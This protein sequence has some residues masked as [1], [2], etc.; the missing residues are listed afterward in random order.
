VFKQ[1][2]P[3]FFGSI[4]EKKVI[5]PPALIVLDI[6]LSCRK[7]HSLFQRSP[8]HLR[9]WALLKR[10]TFVWWIESLTFSFELLQVK[11][12]LNPFDLVA[13]FKTQFGFG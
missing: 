2:K 11:F 13:S 5:M 12:H 8:Q 7:K 9:T 10:A 6:L 3:F 4:Y 1:I